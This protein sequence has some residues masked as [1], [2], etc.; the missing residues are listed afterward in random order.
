MLKDALEGSLLRIQK[1]A[2]HEHVKQLPAAPQERVSDTD[3]RR[4]AKQLKQQHD[5]GFLNTQGRWREYAHRLCDADKGLDGDGLRPGKWKAQQRTNHINLQGIRQPAE[6]VNESG[7]E[8]PRPAAAIKR[9]YLFVEL[10]QVGFVALED[11]DSNGK[12]GEQSAKA[13]EHSV[14]LQYEQQRDHDYACQHDEHH[15]SARV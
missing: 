12:A 14:P 5:T 6:E 2:A 1:R 11:F 8:E 9:V 4:Q 7:A 3:W 13:V 10:V 15:A